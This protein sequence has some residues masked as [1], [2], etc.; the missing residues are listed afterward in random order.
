M[1]CAVPTDLTRRRSAGSGGVAGLAVGQTGCVSTIELPWRRFFDDAPIAI[2]VIDAYGRQVGCNRAYAA[3]F[4][5]SV[6]EMLA[7]DVGRISRPGDHEW[8][9]TYLMRLV[10]GDL[11]SFETDKWYVHRDGSEFLAHLTVS[12]LV[13]DS[14][15]CEYLLGVLVPVSDRRP[16]LGESV[17]ERLLAY[18][19]GSITL[20]DSDGRITFSTGQLNEV[21]G[22]PTSFWAGR[23]LRDLFPGD[24]YDQLLLSRADFLET[25][26]ATF[27][28][29]VEVER[30]DG[31]RQLSAVKAYNCLD[32]EHLAGYVLIT[33][34][35]TAERQRVDDLARRQQTAEEVVDAQTRLLATV[36]HELRNPLHALRGLAE[37]LSREELPPRAAELAGSVVRQLSALTHVTQDLLDAARL[38]AGKVDIFPV[39]TDL[40]RLVGD[41]VGL[42]NAAV[43]DKPVVVGHRIAR[44]VPEW[45]MVD[46][47]RLR[48]VLSNLVGNAAKF[49]DSGSVQIVVRREGE[50]SLV[51]SVIDTGPGIPADEQSAVLEPFRVASTAGEARGAGLG[52]S[53]VQRLV[54]AMGGRVSL[55]SK[56]GDGTRFDVV[57]P[58]RAAR[59]PVTQSSDELPAGLRV[60]VVEDNPVN[61]QLARSQLERLG[62][63]ATIVDRGE[64][65]LAMLLDPDA[66][67]FD[68]VFMDQQ[69]PGWDGTEATERI[70]AEGGVLSTIPIIGLSASASPADRD[71]F[72]ASGMTDFVPK[73][74]SLDDLS[75]AL[76]RAL[77]GSSASASP[78]SSASS[79]SSASVDAVDDGIDLDTEVLDRL[80]DELGSGEIVRDLVRTFLGELDARTSAIVSGDESVARRAAH[81]LKSSAR[82]LGASQLADRCAKIEQDGMTEGVEQ[83]AELTAQACR[84]WLEVP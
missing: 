65:G 14:G 32:D 58:L 38:D 83:L 84:R 26:G 42:G 81:T 21:A 74:A 28:N 13:D 15:A 52:L 59:V 8:S 80:A 29:E 4:G 41:V 17:A 27:Q 44:D 23:R 77:L 60:L 1:V 55:S 9:T 5:Y 39:P 75:S 25:P 19:D 63:E 73:P 71:A 10:S 43:A 51:F 48:Q 76:E 66:G 82:M 62:V 54:T 40:E 3:M 22:Y 30:G 69:L 11:E 37:I 57:I 61:Q 45:V 20:V 79:A 78:A 12:R 6:D 50:A 46:D 34:D 67:P 24:E 16:D 49:T 72:L 70:R 2:S 47:G 7:L 31:R 18:T 68:A 64:A 53:I 36:S 56:V 35:I 33:R